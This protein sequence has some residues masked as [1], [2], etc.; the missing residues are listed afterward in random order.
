MERQSLVFNVEEY[1]ILSHH[2]KVSLVLSEAMNVVTISNYVV[3]MTF[4][5]F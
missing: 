1:I 2:K 4:G 5:P 3:V